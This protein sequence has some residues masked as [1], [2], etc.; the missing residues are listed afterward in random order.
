[1]NVSSTCLIL[2]EDV[3]YTKYLLKIFKSGE[4]F[5]IFLSE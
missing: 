1:M 2:S 3:K 5:E 4:D